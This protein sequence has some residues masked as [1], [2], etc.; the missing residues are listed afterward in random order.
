MPLTD[1]LGNEVSE[2]VRA[3]SNFG[4]PDTFANGELEAWLSRIAEDQPDLTAVENLT[5]RAL[6]QLCSE[7][8]AEVL[9]ERVAQAVAQGGWPAWL[10]ALLGTCHIRQACV[11][12]FNQDTLVEYA[13]EVAGLFAWDQ[14]RWPGYG[15]QP[16]VQWADIL[17]DQPPF[18]GIRLTDT[19]QTTFRLLKLH[20]STN[21]FWR[22]GDLS[23]ATTARWH[24]PGRAPGQDA[25]PDE[26]AALRRALPGRVALIVPPAAAKSNYYQV[27]LLTQLWRDARE[28]LRREHVRISLVGY[29]MPIT[30]LVTSGMLREALAQRPEGSTVVFDVVDPKAEAVLAHLRSLGVQKG[31]INRFE[32]VEVFAAEYEQ[33]AARDLAAALQEWKP[34]KDELDGLL[35]VGSS[36]AGGRKVIEIQRNAGVIE[37]ALERHN[38]P[39]TSTNISPTG[40]PSPLSLRD[41][42]T[43]LG[44]NPV[45]E[46]VAVGPTGGRQLIIGAAEEIRASGAG[47][48]TWQV[49]VT[50]GPI[51]PA[52]QPPL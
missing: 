44:G 8:L 18:P 14:R 2:R 52:V 28:A 4:L 43:H 34:D 51:P 50:A 37:L 6:F 26:A 41:L 7:V 32:S 15:S 10:R 25:V 45:T 29:S 35:L 21:W 30:D 47:N 36:L 12:T 48:G 27:P 49:L 16:Q 11:I 20:G 31:D 42:L 9:G 39:Y 33:R 40:S 46:L 22:P 38:P 19:P 17:D 23:G 3:R 24:L 1:E 5:N 13:V